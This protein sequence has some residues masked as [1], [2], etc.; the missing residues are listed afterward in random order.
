MSMLAP[1]TDSLLFINADPEERARTWVIYGLIVLAV[2]A[3]PP[4]PEKLST[5]RWRRRSGSIW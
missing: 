2:T 3:F 5:G 1:M 4:W